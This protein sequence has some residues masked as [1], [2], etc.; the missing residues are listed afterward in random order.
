[1]THSFRPAKRGDSS[2]MLGLSGPSRSGKTYSALRIAMGAVG[3]D[4]SRIF[5]IDTERGRARMYAD[6][7]GP[8][9]HTDLDP[10]FTSQRYMELVVEAEKADAG[11]II[12]D[13]ASHEHEG[14]GGMLEQHEAFLQEKAGNDYAKR[15]RLTYTAWIKPKFAHNK[16]VNEI[17]RV[18]VNMI[19]CFRA[20]DKLAMVPNARG[21]IEPV[22]QG[23][24]P[25]CSSRFE[26]EMTSILTLPEGAK[27]VPDYDAKATG[28]RD[29]LDQI[30]KPGEQL[31]E[32]HGKLLAE[33]AAGKKARA[34]AKSKATEE[35][36]PDPDPVQHAQLN[37]DAKKIAEERGTIELEKWWKDL[38]GASKRLLKPDMEQYKKLAAQTD[39]RLEGEQGGL[40]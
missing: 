13:S 33:W 2:F 31:C 19:F 24:Q 1:M 18:N 17:L 3:G 11:C 27:G 16:Y 9:L 22:S 8:F 37:L 36:A 12:V 39:D 26:F 23:W 34:P 6:Q 5:F 32:N 25:I 30:L 14:E 28:L 38:P 4:P 40:I 10:P 7:F 20:K 21:K 15:D 35:T 29:P